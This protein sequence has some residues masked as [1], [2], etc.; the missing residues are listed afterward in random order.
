MFFVDVFKSLG[1]YDKFIFL[2]N[3]ILSC[4]LFILFIIDFHWLVFFVFLFNFSI[5]LGYIYFV[6]RGDF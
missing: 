3:C 4:L 5:V 6:K 1:I 2:A